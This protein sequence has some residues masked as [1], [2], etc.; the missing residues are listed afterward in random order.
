MTACITTLHRLILSHYCTSKCC[1][2]TTD[3]LNQLSA[4]TCAFGWP[5][6]QTT[7]VISIY[8]GSTVHKN[9]IVTLTL[10]LF[11]LYHSYNYCYLHAANVDVKVLLETKSTVQLQIN[12]TTT[13]NSSILFLKLTNGAIEQ[14]GANYT[15]GSIE[16]PIN[17]TITLHHL[18]PNTKYT[19]VAHYSLGLTI[20]IECGLQTFTTQ[21]CKYCNVLLMLFSK[22]VCVNLVSHIIT[23]IVS[24]TVGIVFMLLCGIVCTTIIL[25]LCWK[26]V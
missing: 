4:V 21:P 5:T 7:I 25:Y 23:I 9:T 1:A 22:V 12:C 14:S 6:G 20:S 8:Y 17:T 24:T 19:I 15:T 2:G 11:K 18:H 10:L 16:C 26:K 13:L 3:L